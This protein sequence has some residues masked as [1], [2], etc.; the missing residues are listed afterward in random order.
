MKTFK[1][2]VLQEEYTIHIGKY[3]EMP[4]R[5]KKEHKGAVGI[6]NRFDKEI[7]VNECWN[8]DTG[9][10][11]K[12]EWVRKTLRHELIHAFLFESGLGR[13]T[14]LNINA[15]AENEEIVD[16]FAIQSPKIF[17]VFKELDLL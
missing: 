1:V 9:E 4:D 11:G 14:E 5:I 7:F 15:W 2:I 12:T 17:K 13:N 6:C 10:K 16:W 3:D 8:E